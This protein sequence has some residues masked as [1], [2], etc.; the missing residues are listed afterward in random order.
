MMIV[1]IV[2]LILIAFIVWWFWLYKP[3]EKIADNSS[4]ISIIVN[5]GV[6]QP[7]RIKV[8]AGKAITINFLRKDDS[9][10]AATVLF[11]D[12]GISEEL[13]FDA[14]KTVTLEPMVAGEYPFYCKMQMYK[15]VLVVK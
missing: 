11:P 6:Y 15:G 2:G 12:F 7:A 14:S 4:E 5:N 10:C 13:P 8:D 1:N 9:P 3:V